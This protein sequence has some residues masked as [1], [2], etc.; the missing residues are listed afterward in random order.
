M[1]D[2]KDSKPQCFN[3]NKS[4]HFLNSFNSLHISIKTLE[5]SINYV[6]VYIGLKI[7]L[8]F[9]DSPGYGKN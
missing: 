8:A 6:T 5:E 4:V 7:L 1:R 9:E 3:L 2:T